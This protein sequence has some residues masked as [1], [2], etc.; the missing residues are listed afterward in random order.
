MRCS[1]AGDKELLDRLSRT[2]RQRGF[3]GQDG[4]R[5]VGADL[6]TCDDDAF[7]RS[8]VVSGNVRR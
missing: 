5:G 1:C 7:R 3:E 4:D 8:H 2:S 6:I